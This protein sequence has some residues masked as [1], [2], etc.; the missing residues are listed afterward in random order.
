VITAVKNTKTMPENN[1][2]YN[3]AGDAIISTE[4]HINEWDINKCT[5]L[6]NAI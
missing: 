1:T 4:T 3:T 6:E 2:T 5:L